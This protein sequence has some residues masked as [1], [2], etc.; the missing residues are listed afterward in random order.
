MGLT[1]KNSLRLHG[2]C[3][4]V[5]FPIPFQLNIHVASFRPK[6]H[7]IDGSQPVDFV[8]LLHR[9]ANFPYLKAEFTNQVAI[10]AQ[11]CDLGVG[12][13]LRNPHYSNT[14]FKTLNFSTG[15][16]VISK[17]FSICY[18]PFQSQL[19]VIGWYSITLK[20]HCLL[21]PEMISSNALQDDRVEL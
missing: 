21:C 2:R 14:V 1:S 6:Q 9:V 5:W 17:P 18:P 8:C 13:L 20:W 10:K 15:F 7:I 16:P 11:R 12:L 3:W 4:H 19:S